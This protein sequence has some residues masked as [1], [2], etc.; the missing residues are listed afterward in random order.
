MRPQSSRRP[1]AA[2]PVRAVAGM[3]P[4]DRSIAVSQ[5]RSRQYRAGL[6]RAAPAGHD[7][8]RPP[9]AS[10]AGRQ[11]VKGHAAAAAGCEAAGTANASSLRFGLLLGHRHPD[12]ARGGYP[13]GLVVPSVGVPDDAHA[14]VVG[15]H[16]L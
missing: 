4:A 7:P 10:A 6:S 13:A 8:D 1:E 2:G 12:P 11:R 16:P 5:Y 3:T 9:M 14:R 15:Q